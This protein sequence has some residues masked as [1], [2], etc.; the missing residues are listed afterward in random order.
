MANV[1]YHACVVVRERQNWRATAERMLHEYALMECPRA[2]AL[3]QAR[4]RI[5][6]SAVQV[7][8]RLVPQKEP[9]QCDEEKTLRAIWTEQGIS[10]AR[11]DALI[12]EITAMAAP[13]ARIGPFALG[14]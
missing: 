4:Y 1:D 11:Q 13:G 14:Q 7:R 10:V 12:A 8:M 2:K 3:D 9:E 6:V 5:A